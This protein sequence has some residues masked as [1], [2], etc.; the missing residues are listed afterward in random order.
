M[1]AVLFIFF[2]TISAQASEIDSAMLECSSSVSVSES[3]E[4]PDEYEER[5]ERAREKVEAACQKVELLLAS[6]E[7]ETD[8]LVSSIQ[9]L[10]PAS[11][12]SLTDRPSAAVKS[13]LDSLSSLLR[14]L[15]A[16]PNEVTTDNSASLRRL[17]VSLKAATER[18]AKLGGAW[19]SMHLPPADHPLVQLSRASSEPWLPTSARNSLEK[20]LASL[21]PYLLGHGRAPRD[22]L[23]FLEKQLR[24]SSAAL[25][26]KR[27]DYT[28][29]E[30][31]EA[32]ADLRASLE[33]EKLRA[34]AESIRAALLARFG[35]RTPSWLKI[36]SL[37]GACP[38]AHHYASLQVATL[39]AALNEG[40]ARSKAALGEALRNDI[41]A[42]EALAPC[43][44]ERDEA[45]LRLNLAPAA[46]ALSCDKANAHLAAE[47]NTLKADTKEWLALNLASF[48]ADD[49]SAL[50]AVGEELWQRAHS[51]AS[52]CRK[53]KP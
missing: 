2:A 16:L 18:T 39:R 36:A 34:E 12:A 49:R 41:L 53:E 1:S 31:S 48:R 10:T 9:A 6:R 47:A 27:I 20:F 14:E 11:L 45:L 51:L 37:S 29:G 21:P 40:P 25:Q 5:L 13:E 17:D 52:L 43:Q 22:Q 30:R 28:A 35:H 44:G 50:H 4:D 46:A 3:L 32:R 23:L 15:R 38:L 24:L 19:D 7:K 26:G 33:P 42:R 8:S